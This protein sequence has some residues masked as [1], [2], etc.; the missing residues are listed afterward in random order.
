M[1]IEKPNHEM[2]RLFVFAAFSIPI[3]ISDIRSRRIPDAASLG[4]FFLLLFLDI[5]LDR[6]M[7]P[8]R[9]L[10]AA[11]AFCLFLGVRM[12]TK[13]LGFGD[14]K[15]AAFSAYALGPVG[16]LVA[17]PVSAMTGIAYA[18]F[19]ILLRNKSPK[20]RIPY[21]P[22]LLLGAYAGLAARLTGWETFLTG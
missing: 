11:T 13:G 6:A 10:A 9:L 17:F 2:L 18:G 20:D 16:S 7:V 21:A 8:A 5:G 14:V 12:L 19:G 15:L 1:P 22:F 3:L 4:G